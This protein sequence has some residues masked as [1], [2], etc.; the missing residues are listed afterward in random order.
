[1]QFAVIAIKRNDICSVLATGDIEDM[2]IVLD[3]I[4]NE[5]Q[6]NEIKLIE[7]EEDTYNSIKNNALEVHKT[8]ETYF[9]ETKLSYDFLEKRY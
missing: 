1:M 9:T 4:Y 5:Y 7:F 6:D 2:N 3:N 8:L